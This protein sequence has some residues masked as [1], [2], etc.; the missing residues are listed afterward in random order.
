MISIYF[1]VMSVYIKSFIT[2][3]SQAS[4]I[5]SFQLGNGPKFRLWG[6]SSETKIKEFGGTILTEV[7]NKTSLYCTLM[8]VLD[9]ILGKRNLN[10]RGE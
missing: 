1:D 9:I 4:H 3:K 8:D 7:H 10:G 6:W 2:V 5:F